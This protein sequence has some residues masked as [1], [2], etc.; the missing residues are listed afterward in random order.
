MK[1]KEI[2]FDNNATT[3]PLPEVREEVLKVMG[4]EF[5]N[6]SSAHL[7]GARARKH[8]SQAREQLAQLIGS[9]SSKIIFT[10]SGTEA[11]N[12]AFYSCT[13][14]Q[15]NGCEILTTTI[16]HSSI[17]KM[18]NFLKL[19]GVSVKKL[20]VNSQGLINLEELKE[21][22]NENTSLV[23]IQLVNNETGVIQPISEI[24][25]ICRELSVPLHTDAAQAVGKMEMNIQGM[26]IDF[27]SLT[28]HKFHSPQGVGAIYC[29]DK[30][31][32]A[33]MLFGGFQEEGFRPGTENVPGITGMGK[34][35]E[36]RKNN[37]SELISKMKDLRDRFEAMLLDFVPG[38]KVNGDTKNRVCNTSNIMFSGIDGRRLVKELDQNG[39]RC[40]QSSACT[41]FEIAPSY[42]LRAMGLTEEEAYSSIR[43]SFSVENT[44]DEIDSVIEIIRKLTD[45]LKN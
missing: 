31:L 27:L 6:P 39:V 1:Q 28:G 32:L 7:T 3:K 8:I 35:A 43:F 2:Y 33:P 20:Q 21:S 42:V 4:P 16:E 41:N 23:S 10:G 19:N 14:D 44:Y 12:M 13:R 5:G 34:A 22:I 24:G 29:K 37:L 11:N 38:T 40:S 18:S 45:E 15:T 30:F 17:Q 9:D 26:P 25:E 36:I